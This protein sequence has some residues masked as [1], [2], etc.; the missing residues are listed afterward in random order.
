MFEVTDKYSL[1]VML[2]LGLFPLR[3]RYGLQFFLNEFAFLHFFKG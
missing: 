3:R 1:S 2:E